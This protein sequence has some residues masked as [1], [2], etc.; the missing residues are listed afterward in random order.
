LHFTP[1]ETDIYKIHQSGDLANLD[2]LDDSSLARLPSLLK[3]RD[4]LYS[5]AFRGYISHVA[6]AGPVSGK[7]TDMAINVYTPTCHLLC[8]D[9]VI[10][11]RRISYIL[12]LTDPDLPWKAEW[13]GALRLYPT[14][15]LSTDDGTE[16]L[17]P[18]AD[19]SV[20]IPPAFNQLSFF[21][22][23]PGKSFHDVE[24][25]YTRKEGEDAGDGGRVRMAISGWFHIPQEGEEG[26][27]EGMEERL[28]ER[29]SLNQL[30][31]SKAD[32]FDLPQSQWR[33]VEGAPE[34]DEEEAPFTNDE[35]DW[36][37]R[38][39]NPTYLTPD[40]VE[41]LR[42]SFEENSA[43]TLADFLHPKFAE[44]L[45]KYLE[46]LDGAPSSGFPNLK[47]AEEYAGVA[48][49]PHKHR[50]LYRQPTLSAIENG[51]DTPLDQLVE[52]LLPSPLFIRWLSL[53]TGL[54]FT[55][56]EFLVRRFRRGMDYTLAT[57]YAQPQPQLELC[58]GITPTT[59]WGEDDDNEDEDESE[60]EIPA[61]KPISERNGKK[62]EAKKEELSSS[63][64][65]LEPVGG[66]EM[67]MAGDEE[68]DDG[69]SHDGIEIPAGAAS[70]TGA[71]QRKRTKADPA[72]YRSSGDD[73]EDDVLFSNPAGWNKLTIVLRDTGVM[74]FV[75][76]VSD[77][78]KGDRWDMTANFSVV[79]EE[80]EEVEDE[81]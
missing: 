7:K 45:R 36:L 39:L 28:A 11:S 55:R 58:L 18:S 1:K 42:E 16:T 2:G 14:Q 5:H 71:G 12:Y 60:D 70:H 61:R 44:R 26:Y 59:G 68:D 81:A 17:V 22:I 21:A 48:R 6:N 52:H 50:F 13:G 31:Q 75:K 63:D 32:V 24:E 29:S 64:S 67:Y 37:L 51:S 41:A 49:P 76:Y 62:S 34:R 20:S 3:L 8:H 57:S 4:A 43:A 69:D 23:Q 30:Q 72:V 66:Y 19:F 27:E 80:E 10:G 79:D 33:D 25:V 54:S 40:T 15:A 74:K 38:F 65:G 46:P 78:A 35:L 56:A 9:D 47:G 73:E 77:S 53:I